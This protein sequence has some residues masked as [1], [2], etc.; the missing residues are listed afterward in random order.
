MADLLRQL[1][2]A[3]LGGGR[4]VGQARALEE[5]H[6]VLLPE[7]A[8]E[9]LAQVDEGVGRLGVPDVGQPRLHAPA[10]VVADHLPHRAPPPVEAAEICVWKR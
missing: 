4:R 6:D 8:L 10:Q 2:V 7:D 5:G 1:Q 3:R 9:L